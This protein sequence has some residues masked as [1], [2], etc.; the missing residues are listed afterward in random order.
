MIDRHNCYEAI[1]EALAEK[2]L[3]LS[4]AIQF[5]PTT[6]AILATPRIPV[7][8]LDDSRAAKKKART[9]NM[10]AS[11]CPFCGVVLPRLDEPGAAPASEEGGAGA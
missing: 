4:M 2:G 10:L 1:N 11:F 8:P 7:E 3:R 9:T 6:G 5:S